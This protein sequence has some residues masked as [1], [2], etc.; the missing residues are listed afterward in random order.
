[1]FIT[2]NKIAAFSILELLVAM[3]IAS[4]LM[5]TAMIGLQDITLS[6]NKSDAKAQV[7]SHLRLAQVQSVNEGGRGVLLLA[8]D[9]L[10]YSFGYDYIT[11]GYDTTSPVSY[12]ASAL[13]WTKNLPN[14]IKISLSKEV[15]FD[16]KG[17]VID[18]FGAITDVDVRFYEQSSGSDVLYENACLS[19]I[20]VMT[21]GATC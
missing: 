3:S 18:S 6:L 20:G 7:R 19:S 15:I 10:S 11:D 21:F 8:A 13:Q 5:G 16:S 14:L 2:N 4:I 1:M 12:D 9:G 17:R